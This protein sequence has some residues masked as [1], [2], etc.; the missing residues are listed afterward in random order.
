MLYVRII[1]NEKCLENVSLYIIKYK[2]K[3]S[4][5]SYVRMYTYG[6]IVF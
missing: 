5:N 2:N 6:N 3:F 4:N 1:K